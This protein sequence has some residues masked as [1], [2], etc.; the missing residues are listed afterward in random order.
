MPVISRSILHNKLALLSLIVLAM[1]GFGLAATYGV[2]RVV[3]EKAVNNAEDF[4][5]AHTTAEMDDE[6]KVLRLAKAVYQANLDS[7]RSNVVPFLFHLRPYLEHKF[8]PE[9][10]RIKSGAI[11]VVYME[12]L[13]DSAARRLVYVL[14]AAGYAATQLNIVSPD[15]GHSIT[16]MKLPSGLSVMLDPYFGAASIWNGRMIGPSDTQR[17]MQQGVPSEKIWQPFGP[18]ARLDFYKNFGRS[19]IAEQG[20]PLTIEVSVNLEKGESFS[21]GDN[22]N[23]PLD[24]SIAAAKRGWSPYWH[25]MGHRYDRGWERVMHF[26]HKMRVTFALTREVNKDFI[27]SKTPPSAIHENLVIYKLNAGQ[28]LHFRD[29]QAKRDWFSMKSFQDVDYIL[30]E[31]LD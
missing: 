1:L 16:L 30:F 5:A 17:L 11:E 29:A 31:A 28:V 3:E 12:G 25:Y 22:D 13:C 8:M 2:K 21:L 19:S 27:T 14:D 9:L 23:S 18:E 26:K 7:Q 6:E 15:G 10:V 4:I 20:Q 24:V